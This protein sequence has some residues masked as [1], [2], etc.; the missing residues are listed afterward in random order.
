MFLTT[1]TNVQHRIFDELLLC[2]LVVPVQIMVQFFQDPEKMSVVA[3]KLLD[4]HISP[5]GPLHVRFLR[6]QN[7][8][9]SAASHFPFSDIQGMLNRG[10]Q[11]ANLA[12]TTYRPCIRYVAG[13][14]CNAIVASPLSPLA[15]PFSWM[16][17]SPA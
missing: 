14:L 3:E 17:L 8:I 10:D 6:K 1:G 4:T 5:T 12:G 9:P 15:F 7:Q 11:D 13:I 2:N 16:S